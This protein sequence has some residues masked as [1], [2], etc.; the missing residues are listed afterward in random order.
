MEYDTYK[1]ENALG[2][3]FHNQALL[4]QAFIRRS[5]SEEN[6][7]QNN[8]VLEFIG[9]KALDLAVIIILT[10]RFGMTTDDKR[11]KE[12]KLKNPEY[13]KTKS[14]E[15]IFTDIKKDLVQKKTLAEAITNLGFH[16]MFFI[17]EG[18]FKN[19]IHNQD[20]VKEDLF[21]AI[22]GAVA[23]DCDYD[24]NTIV[25]VVETMID[26]DAY[27]TNWKE[28]NVN[29]VGML[30]EWFQNN[31]MPVPEY[32]YEK[33]H[34]YGEESFIC[35]VSLTLDDGYEESWSGEGESKA[36]A[37]MEAARNAYSDLKQ[38]GYIVSE[39]EE[40]VGEPDENESIRQVNELVQKKLIS[41][42]TYEFS[43]GK[44]EYGDTYWTC[45]CRVKEIADYYF[46]GEAYNKRDSQRQAAY[47]LLKH[48]MG[49]EDEE[50]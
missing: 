28:H 32:E 44:D 13:F 43:Q 18:D 31:E 41:S 50:E 11:W 40:E 39:Y 42:P 19:D 1:I 9:D 35:K 6:G 3:H 23:I 45:K 16:L 36:K 49:Y 2:Y 8:E 38:N 47:F 34:Y 15:G 26:F 17:G 20:S 33:R 5:Y 14:K 21:E 24:M 7:G 22:V 29:Y 12:F 10:D 46:T 30:Q 4:Q 27:F 37:R 48:L 25:S